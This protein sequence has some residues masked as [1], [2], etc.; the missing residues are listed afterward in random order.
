MSESGQYGTP[1]HFVPAHRDTHFVADG[2]LLHGKV[3]SDSKLARVF[4][5]L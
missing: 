4:E 5:R 1:E 2:S 3:D